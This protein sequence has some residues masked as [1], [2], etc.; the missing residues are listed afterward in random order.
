MNDGKYGLPK[1]LRTYQVH[2]P[3]CPPLQPS[4]IDDEFTATQSGTGAPPGWTS[5]G[6]FTPTYEMRNGVLTLASAQNN[7]DAGAAM[8]ERVLPSGPFSVTVEHTLLGVESVNQGGL[9]VRSSVSGRVICLQVQFN[10]SNYPEVTATRHTSSTAAPEANFPQRIL[11]RK[12]FLR[13]SHDGT[14][15]QAHWSADGAVWQLIFQHLTIGTW[16]TGGNLPDRIGLR[17]MSKSPNVGTLSMYRAF[18]HVPTPRADSGR[19]LTRE[20]R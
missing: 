17:V 15:L 9:Y 7:T 8:I 19:M 4:V 14:D 2:D 5:V 3:L 16:F 10:I 13:W 20:I 18:R 1:R 6:P 12:G 11:S